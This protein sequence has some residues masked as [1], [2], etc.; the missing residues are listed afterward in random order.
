MT[1]RCPDCDGAITDVAGNRDVVACVDCGLVNPEVNQPEIGEENPP[2]STSGNSGK[3]DTE[4]VDRGWKSRVCVADS[5]D[6]NLIDILSLVDTYIENTNLSREVR[7][8]AAEVVIS[9]WESDLFEGRQKE[10]VTTGSVYAAARELH[11]PRPLTILCDIAEVRESTVNDAY[12]LIVSELGIEI[13]IPRPEDYVSYIGE[14]MSLSQALIHEAAELL[15]QEVNCRGN[16]AGIAASMLYLLA[17]KDC[18][19]TLTQAGD[20][21]GVSKETVWR[22]SQAIRDSVSELV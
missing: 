3:S 19:V 1:D 13:P 6:E 7:L 2:V 12:R 17:R 11:Q 14:E 18:D 21:S 15:E 22:H 16:P 4:R 20:A 10:V 5:S 9:A 8:R